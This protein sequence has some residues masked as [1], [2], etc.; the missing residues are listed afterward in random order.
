MGVAATYAINAQPCTDHPLRQ[1]ASPHDIRAHLLPEDRDE[2]DAAY[3][4]G[5]AEAGVS[6]DLSELFKTLERWRRKAMGAQATG[7]DGMGISDG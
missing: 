5:L 2:F 3:E 6:L 7:Q 4:A 1:G